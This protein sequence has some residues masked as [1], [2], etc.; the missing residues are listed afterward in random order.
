MKVLK[1]VA[2]VLGVLVG[3]IVIGAFIIGVMFRNETRKPAINGS[4]VAHKTRNLEPMPRPY[5][6]KGRYRVVEIDGRAWLMDRRDRITILRGATVKFDGATTLGSDPF[7]TARQLRDVGFNALRVLVPWDDINNNQDS[8]KLFY[9]MKTLMNAAHGHDMVVHFV[10]WFD[11]VPGQ[12]GSSGIPAVMNRGDLAPFE[13]SK[14]QFINQLRTLALEMRWWSDFN[15]S[16]WSFDSK[17]LQDHLIDPWPKLVQLFGGHPALLGLTP[18]HTPVCYPGIVGRLFNPGK[19]DCPI[20]DFQH[21]FIS[22]VRAND[23]N[24]VGIMEPPVSGVPCTKGQVIDEWEKPDLPNI[25]TAWGVA[26]DNIAKM[27]Q[28]VQD[29]RFPMFFQNEDIG[30]QPSGSEDFS[31]WCDTL[32]KLQASGYVN[33]ADPVNPAKQLMQAVNRPYPSRVAGVPTGWSL[34]DGTFTLTI[35][36]PVKDQPTM[37]YIPPSAFGPDVTWENLNVTVT[38]G[39]YKTHARNPNMLLWF[40]EPEA[41]SAQI[42]VGV[43]A[44]TGAGA[45]T[46]T[47]TGAG[48]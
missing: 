31:N 47:G 18:I 16:L 14:Y 44:G 9:D 12:P 30:E 4:P 22:A 28:L 2:I 15:Q 5:K 34:Q 36:S 39:T 46:G 13:P 48:G 19:D 6:A 23:S 26:K 33:L 7:L 42:V 8:L 32:D 27:A 21:R 10:I 11:G 35:K 43:G 25:I 20:S 41:E 37:V 45:G 24:V 40:V 1:V 29:G 17:S 38:A 3:L